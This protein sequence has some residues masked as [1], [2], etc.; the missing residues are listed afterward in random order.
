MNGQVVLVCVLC[1]MC[2]YL[3]VLTGMWCVRVHAVVHVREIFV[4][5]MTVVVLKYLDEP[6]PVQ[7]FISNSA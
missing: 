4:I 5:R 7:S 3:C 6:H 1:S 2:V